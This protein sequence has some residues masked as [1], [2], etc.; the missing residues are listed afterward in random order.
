MKVGTN[1][2]YEKIKNMARRISGLP[3]RRSETPRR[4]NLHLRASQLVL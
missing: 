3:R 4:A 1:E 2:E